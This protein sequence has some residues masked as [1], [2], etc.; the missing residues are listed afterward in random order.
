MSKT[1]IKSHTVDPEKLNIEWGDGHASSYH[2]MWL[3]DNAPENRH[4]NGQKLIDTFSIPLDLTAKSIAVNG[5]VKIEWS[6]DGHVTEF[7]PEWL[8]QHSYEESE[9]AARR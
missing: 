4:A 2:Y 6:N 8:R 3:R 7:T 5:T 9:V 1:T